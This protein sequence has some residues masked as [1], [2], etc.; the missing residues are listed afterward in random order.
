M[1]SLRVVLLLGYEDGVEN[2]G[3]A[4]KI[5]FVRAISA[6]ISQKRVWKKNRKDSGEIVREK[7]DV[8]YVD[9]AVTGS[10]DGT[11]INYPAVTLLMHLY[12]KRGL[13]RR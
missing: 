2:G 11:G 10:N 3:V 9:C 5:A 8:Y 1:M 13:Q 7:D 4:H 6:K 12:N